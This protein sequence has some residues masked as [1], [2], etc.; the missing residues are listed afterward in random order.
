VEAQFRDQPEG[1]YRNDFNTVVK[2]REDSREW[3]EIFPVLDR[4]VR[5]AAREIPAR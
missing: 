5:V 2:F 4:G 1:C 3:S